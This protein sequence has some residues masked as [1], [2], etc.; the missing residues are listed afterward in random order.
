[1]TRPPDTV[2]S[3]GG[4]FYP[5]MLLNRFDT[6]NCFCCLLCYPLPAYCECDA[7]CDDPDGRDTENISSRL[8]QEVLGDVAVRGRDLDDLVA[9]L[10]LELQVLPTAVTVGDDAS[11]V[12]EFDLVAVC[13]SRLHVEDERR[14]VDFSRL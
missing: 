14:V 2:F 3:S 10:S 8:R 6:L 12:N 7:G 4:L 1:M 5:A 11:H 9:V 13:V